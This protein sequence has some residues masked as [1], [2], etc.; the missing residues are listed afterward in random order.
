M[1]KWLINI[2]FGDFC[3]HDWYCYNTNKEQNRKGE[4]IN[5][6]DTLICNKC[7]KITQIDL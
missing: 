1:I 4:M 5:I 2:I 7:G 6:R 3:K